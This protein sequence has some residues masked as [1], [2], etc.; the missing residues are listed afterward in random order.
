[1]KE[2]FTHSNQMAEC[3]KLCRFSYRKVIVNDVGLDE[4]SFLVSWCRSLK[5]I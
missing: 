3:K 1:M 2:S 4:N 5:Q